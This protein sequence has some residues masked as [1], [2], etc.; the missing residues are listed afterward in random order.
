MGISVI[1][2]ENYYMTANGMPD[3]EES[4]QVRA[5]YEALSFHL[6]LVCDDLMTSFSCCGPAPDNGRRDLRMPEQQPNVP[7]SRIQRKYKTNRD[8]YDTKKTLYHPPPHY[9]MDIRKDKVHSHSGSLSGTLRA[10]CLTHKKS[11]ISWTRGSWPC[12]R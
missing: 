11:Q 10:S 9:S 12:S 6:I 1:P 8:Q 3:K 5:F 4:K 7:D 2:N